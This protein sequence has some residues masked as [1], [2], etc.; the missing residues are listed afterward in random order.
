MNNGKRSAFGALVLSAAGLIGLVSHEGFTDKAVI[1][2]PGDR[3]TYGFGSTFK[4]DGSPV[5]MGDTIT[6]QKALRLTMIHLAKDDVRL[7]QCVT[8]EL[9]Q[10][11]YDILKDFSYWRGAGGT[12]RSDVVKHINTGDYVASCNAYL[13]LDSRKAAGKDCKE[14]GS[15]CRGVWVRAQKR[16]SDCMEAQ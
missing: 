5:K 14:P 13:N 9:N 3:A 16:Y 6:P 15:G 11:E 12:C 1:P 2:V 10:K 8:G 4:E 7:K